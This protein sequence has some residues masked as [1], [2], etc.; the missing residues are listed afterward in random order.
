[1]CGKFSHVEVAAA[2]FIC[3][4]WNERFGPQLTEDVIRRKH[5]N[6][7][8]TFTVSYEKTRGQQDVHF[9]QTH[10]LFRKLAG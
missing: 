5:N 1:M 3:I 9:D 8:F 2:G 7:P 4:F 10:E 6:K